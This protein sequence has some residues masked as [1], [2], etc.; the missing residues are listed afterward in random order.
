[1]WVRV[2][3]EAHNPRTFDRWA[4]DGTTRGT[5]LTGTGKPAT[6]SWFSLDPIAKAVSILDDGSMENIHKRLGY[7]HKVRNFYNNIIDPNS[8]KGDVR[9]TRMQSRLGTSVLWV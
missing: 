7:Q 1:M 9:L 5:A 2:F 3:D 8:N 4:P 6:A